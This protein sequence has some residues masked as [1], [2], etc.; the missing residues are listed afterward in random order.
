M[1]ALEIESFRSIV[2]WSIAAYLVAV[3]VMLG[4][5]LDPMIAFMG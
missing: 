2:R 5:D 4:L 1:S 3:I